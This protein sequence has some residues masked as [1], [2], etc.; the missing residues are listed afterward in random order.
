MLHAYGLPLAAPRPSALWNRLPSH[1]HRFGVWGGSS[2]LNMAI[3]WAGL[4]DLDGA[5]TPDEMA[6]CLLT[7]I[8]RPA[9]WSPSGSQQQEEGLGEEQVAYR[10]GI[11]YGCAPCAGAAITGGKIVDHPRRWPLYC[12]RWSRW[13]WIDDGTLAGRSGRAV[14]SCSLAVVAHTAGSSKK[15]WLHSRRWGPQ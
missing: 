6:T 10:Q 8:W 1:R 7:E 12:H 3:S 15:P 9:R 4:V 2:R 11:R 13:P 5:S 14:T